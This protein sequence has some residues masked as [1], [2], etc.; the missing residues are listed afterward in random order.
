MSLIHH[1]R[2]DYYKNPYG[3]VPCDTAVLLRCDYTDY[4]CFP[5]LYFRYEAF[6]FCR[7]FS[8]K[9]DKTIIHDGIFTAEYNLNSTFFNNAGLYFYWFSTEKGE[10]TKE[11]QITVYEKQL[12]VPKWFLNSII[13]QVFPDR[14]YKAEDNRAL[15]KSNSFMYSDWNDI[16]MYIKDNQQRIAR[17]EFFGGNLKGIEEKLEYI[18]ELGADTVYI[19][20]IFEARSNHRY[21]TAD[22]HKIDSL[23]GGDD[24]FDELITAM[25]LENMHVVLDG[26]FNHT[27]KCSKYF[28]DCKNENSLYKDWYSFKDDGTYD[29]WW[30]VDDLPSINKSCKSF[31]EFVADSENSVVRYWSR[32]G[33]DGWR[34]DV[35]DELSDI[36]LQKIRSAAEKEIKEPVIIGE[37][38]ENASNKKSYGQRK[39]YFTKPELHTHTNY[40]FRDS[41]MAFFNGSV[42][43]YDTAEVF[44]NIKETYP[45][46]N[47]YA[48]VN[49]TGSHDVERLMS[50]MLNITK[51]DRRLARD[52]IKCYSLIQFTAVGVPLVY[53]GDETCLEGGKDPDNRRTYPWGNEDSEM[54]KWFA[55]LAVMRKSL[56]T[57]VFGDAEYFGVSDGNVFAMLRY[58]NDESDSD[59]LYLTICDRFGRGREFLDACIKNL[60]KN[61]E[62]IKEKSYIIEKEAGGYGLLVSF[63]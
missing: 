5:V 32:K 50:L 23:L 1:S 2:Q 8:F 13:Y 16:P 18:K 57:L 14:F 31:A 22:Y 53:Y 51:N 25:K 28:S 11:Y 26:V 20:P 59:A 40:V 35:A 55:D 63:L 56:T 48:Q 19:N 9:P 46:H 27:G 24:A 49:M 21:D 12:T 7:T 4:N 47:F 58:S 34:L 45:K 38:W 54:I 15:P 39:M 61:I 17:W 10:R 42:S 33:I 62:K 52:L 36:L 29:C 41:L 60:S 6:D 37:V 43:G 3:A 44:E 30:G